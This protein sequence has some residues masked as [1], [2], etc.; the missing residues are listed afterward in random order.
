VTTHA[1]R[2]PLI[3]LVAALGA[4]NA[5]AAPARGPDPA[6]R[7]GNGDRAGGRGRDGLGASFR[8][9]GERERGRADDLG[10]AENL[11]R[12]DPASK[13][14]RPE[15]PLREEPAFARLIEH[16]PSLSKIVD[17]N[18]TTFRQGLT[19]GNKAI[20]EKAA[21]ILNGGEEAAPAKAVQK[22]APPESLQRAVA[23][24]R[25]AIP[26][27]ERDRTLE[28]PHFDV[29]AARRAPVVYMRAYVRDLQARSDDAQEKLDTLGE[30]IARGSPDA[31]Y[32]RR[33]DKKDFTRIMQKVREKDG[34]ASQLYDL[35]AGRVVFPTM[36]KLSAALEHAPQ[37]LEG[38]GATIVRVKERFTE[39]MASGYRD[40]LM[41]IRT[42]EGIVTELRF[43]LEPLVEIAKQEHLPY[44]MKRG[45]DDLASR[46][47]RELS[48]DEA[49]LKDA[50]DQV[51]RPKY[52]QAFERLLREGPQ[53]WRGGSPQEGAAGA[54]G[55]QRAVG[56]AP[57]R[58]EPGR[59]DRA[60]GPA[61]ARVGVAA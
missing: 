36:E 52:D 55:P 51:T 43:E 35:A 3:V 21:R 20:L 56:R 4:V 14:E 38:T 40:V 6:R 54:R 7:P 61:G 10:R 11:G 44:E 58:G 9:G 15:R 23:T 2:A 33:P 1:P 34:I 17:K 47:R 57:E 59:R 8:G 5:Q 24:A 26:R 25:Q 13:T 27:T 45:L 41:N 22:I 49:R 32:E 16:V 28:Q 31:H 48:P 18:E 46:E 39:P 30:Q 29:E 19:D 37:A 42:R 53:S 12:G 50:L 60:G